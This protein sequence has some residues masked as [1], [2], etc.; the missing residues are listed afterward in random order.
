MQEL[1]TE[2][3]YFGDAFGLPHPL[4]CAESAGWR[5]ERKAAP[6]PNRLRVAVWPRVGRPTA[7]GSES[8]KRKGWQWPRA[9][10]GLA[11]SRVIWNVPRAAGLELQGLWVLLSSRIFQVSF[12]PLLASSPHQRDWN[13]QVLTEGCEGLNSHFFVIRGFPSVL[14]HLPV[15]EQLRRFRGP[16]TSARSLQGQERFR[17]RL[18]FELVLFAVISPS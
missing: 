2:K 18:A 10:L 14:P 17:T 16:T 5:G 13:W 15:S 9:P 12:F 7:L 6:T 8:P 11:C 3:L 4:C 1:V